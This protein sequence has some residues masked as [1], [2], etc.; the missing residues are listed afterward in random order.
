MPPLAR[1]TDWLKV[2]L[3]LGD[4]KKTYRREVN[5]MPQWA[6]SCWY[7][8]RYLDPTN[9]ERFVD[10]QVERYWMGPKHAGH[11]GGVDLYVGGVEHAV[12]HLLY[13]RFFTRALNRC[14]YLQTKEPFKNLLTQGMVCH[15]TFKNAK[16]EWIYPEQADAN[17]VKGA[18]IKMSKSKKN[19]VNPQSILEKYGADTARLFML[20]DS[21]PERDLDWSDEGVEGCHK[22]LKR[23]WALAKQEMPAT[24]NDEIRRLAH[25]TIAETTKAYENSAFNV[26]V[27]QIRTLFN[28]LVKSPNREAVDIMLKLLQPLCPHICCELLGSA[29]IDFPIADT[30]LLQVDVVSVAVQVNGK[31]RGLIELPAGCDEAQAREIALS[32]ENVAEFVAGGIKKFIYVPNR[33]INI[34]A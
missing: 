5:V 13:A 25:K 21:P 1:V 22:F 15:P 20:S 31:K 29:S 27:A 6:G 7:E 14:G 8:L 34:V 19:V 10:A 28:E 12:L 30:N 2:E 26:A 17:S 16:G 33:I 18:S 11:T 3:D 32:H 4:G 9:I 23:V 24:G